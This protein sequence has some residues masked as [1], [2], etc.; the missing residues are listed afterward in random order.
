M[1][2]VSVIVATYR[3]DAALVAALRSLGE[4]TYENLEILLVD[5]NA[6][7]IWSEKV[8]AAVAAF[9]E[10]Y[11]RS[12]LRLIV[13]DPN[14]G[15]AK[16]RNVGIFAAEGE[17]ITFLDDD[18]VYLP[19][20]VA[21]QLAHMK[22][23]ASDFSITDLELFNEQD[24]LIDRRSRDYLV[25]VAPDALLSLHLKHHMTGTDTMMF[26]REYLLAIG[27]FEPIDV[28][29]EFYLMQ[30]AI[31]AGGRFSYLPAC[32]IRAYV[33]TGDGG[34]SSGRGK[35]EGEKA[36]YAYKK[37]SFPSLSR[38]DRR[39]IRMRHHAVLAFAYLRMRRYG[40]FFTSAMHS[41]FA[42]PLGALRLFLS[43]RG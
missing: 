25:G 27:G 21:R 35:I 29:D 30:K 7:P 3:R 15:S 17:Y 6:D 20:K 37:R 28:G 22:E 42:S 31:E 5:D 16:T 11:P 10:Q 32:D 40:R 24:K 19:E 26:R 2:R 43:R 23:V 38:R 18:D 34:V 13:N 1:E 4:Q 41:F 14:L 39:Y 12:E 36:L 33:H 8:A 9:R